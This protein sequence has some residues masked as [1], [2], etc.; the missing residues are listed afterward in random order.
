MV[1]DTVICMS[2]NIGPLDGRI[3][4]V[5]Q[6]A[7]RFYP[8]FGQLPGAVGIVLLPGELEARRYETLVLTEEPA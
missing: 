1:G 6:P 7:K 8:C 4:T 3:K 5:K 2:S